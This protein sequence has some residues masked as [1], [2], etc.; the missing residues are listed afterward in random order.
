M[1]ILYQNASLARNTSNQGLIQNKVSNFNIEASQKVKTDIKNLKLMRAEIMR[2]RSKYASG[3]V[4][5]NQKVESKKLEAELEKTCNMLSSEKR[6]RRRQRDQGMAMSIDL[7]KKQQ[8]LKN[9]NIQQ[10]FH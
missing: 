2:K 4:H 9:R 6:S 1:G 7:L 10:N 8:N 5:T 3:A